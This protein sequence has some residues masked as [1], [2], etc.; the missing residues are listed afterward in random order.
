MPTILTCTSSPE[1]RQKAT[2]TDID[3]NATDLVSTFG[4][5][6]NRSLDPV[7]DPDGMETLFLTNQVGQR[8]RVTRGD[9]LGYEIEFV[10]GSNGYLI[11][12]QV[13]N[14]DESGTRGTTTPWIITTCSPDD[15][16]RPTS[17]A[18]ALL[19]GTRTTSTACGGNG[20]VK[21]ITLP[22]GNIVKQVWDERGLL[23]S[24]CRGFGSADAS[25][26]SWEYDGNGN[27]VSYV[28]GRSKEY[29]QSFNAYDQLTTVT[30][31]P[32][33]SVSFVVD[34]MG[35]QTEIK[36]TN[37]SDTLL[38]HRKQYFDELGQVYDV[39]SWLDH[40]A[41]TADEWMVT[42][43]DRDKRGLVTLV[44]DSLSHE[45]ENTWDNA[46]RLICQEEHLGNKTWYEQNG[47]GMVT[48]KGSSGFRD[49]K[50]IR[51]GPVVIPD[52]PTYT[53]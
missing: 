30:T 47:I 7:T 45:T 15:L 28:N 41:P 39:E 18:E 8:T 48:K 19:T 51:P 23:A 5:D 53:P 3:N 14:V 37:S 35:H 27:M 46:R 13:E 42:E 52:L 20:E 34:K 31:P 40:T 10:Y 6:S 25:T 16:G 36:R 9:S 24:R 17:V 11:N 4:Y 44:T 26:E 1:I 38:A 21:Q 22:E 32:G 33:H 2:D 29:E 50:F 12:R 43:I 49:R